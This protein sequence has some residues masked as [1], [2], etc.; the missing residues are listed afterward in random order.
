MS[1]VPDVLD[2]RTYKLKPGAGEGF[3]RIFREAAL[4]MMT[5]FGIDVAVRGCSL[6]DPDVYYLVR[7]FSSVEDRDERLDAFYGSA[8]WRQR[9]REQVLA[10]IDSY[11]V[12][13]LEASLLRERLAEPLQQ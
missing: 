2:L 1:R 8:E 4:P 5:R 12:A 3:D 11:H 10:M 9:Y 6:E 13:L 7:A